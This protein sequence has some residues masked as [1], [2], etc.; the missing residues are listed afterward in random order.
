MSP[1]HSSIIPALYCNPEVLRVSSCIDFIIDWSYWR[2]ITPLFAFLDARKFVF[3]ESLSAQQ[4]VISERDNNGIGFGPELFCACEQI[5]AKEWTKWF[6][7]RGLVFVSSFLLSGWSPCCFTSALPHLRAGVSTCFLL[8]V[9]TFVY[10][11]GTLKTFFLHLNEIV[12]WW[13]EDVSSYKIVFHH[14]GVPQGF[15]G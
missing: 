13:C 5:N 1:H 6:S 8:F 2:D 12:Y 7:H 4:S 11:Y 14:Y 15:F 9:S 3:A 10:H